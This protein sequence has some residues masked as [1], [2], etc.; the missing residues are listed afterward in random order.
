MSVFATVGFS[1]F[2]DRGSIF[3]YICP[4]NAKTTPPLSLFLSHWSRAVMEIAHRTLFVT[5]C[6]KS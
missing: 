3:M 5:S 6:G 2:Y 1:V 4:V